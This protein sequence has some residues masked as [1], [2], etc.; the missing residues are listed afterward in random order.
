MIVRHLEIHYFL[1]FVGKYESN[2][3]DSKNDGDFAND[4]R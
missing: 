1:S 2:N 4:Y 3:Q